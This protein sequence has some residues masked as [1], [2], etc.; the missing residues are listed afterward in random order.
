MRKKWRAIITLLACW[1]LLLGGTLAI[2]TLT[3]TASAAPKQRIEDGWSIVRNATQNRLA[4]TARKSG[5]FGDLSL[6]GFEERLYPITRNGFAHAVR[7]AKAK[8]VS[9]AGAALDRSLEKTQYFEISFHTEHAED[10]KN[11]GHVTDVTLERASITFTQTE[12]Q[13]LLQ[14]FSDLTFSVDSTL[15]DHRVFHEICINKHQRK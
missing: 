4:L 1:L 14:S 9:C 12:E 8:F 10:S 6:T 11:K 2:R 5:G 7:E 3:R 15:P 13:C